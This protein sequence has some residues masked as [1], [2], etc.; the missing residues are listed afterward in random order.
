MRLVQVS[1]HITTGRW[2]GQF[3][4]AALCGKLF[5]EFLVLFVGCKL[6]MVELVAWCCFRENLR[7]DQLRINI[8]RND[9][10]TQFDCRRWQLQ[11]IHL[12]HMRVRVVFGR[13]NVASQSSR[14]RR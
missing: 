4:K 6:D 5:S 7:Q 13:S 3:E 12:V 2:T 14:D 9:P 1:E 10:I 11:G 8:M